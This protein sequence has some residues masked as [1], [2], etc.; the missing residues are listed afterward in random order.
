MLFAIT[1]TGLDVFDAARAWGLAALIGDLTQDEVRVRDIGWQFL[2]DSDSDVGT[3][4]QVSQFPIVPPDTD[5]VWRN[6]FVTSGES[7][8]Q[9]KIEK[10]RELIV[11]LASEPAVMQGIFGGD[12]SDHVFVSRGG[13]SLP[14]ALD[15]AAF[16]GVRQQTRA[17]YAEDQLKVEERHWALACLGMALCGSYRKVRTAGGQR[18]LV[19]LPIPHDVRVYQPSEFGELT[20]WTQE[21]GHAAAATMA[22]H[23]AVDLAARLRKRAAVY[24]Q[25]RDRFSEIVFF[26]LFR[27]GNQPKPAQ[28]NH[29]RLERLLTVVANDP[30]RAEG[31]LAWLDYCF[32]R[33]AVKGFQELAL[34]ATEFTFRWDLDSYERLVRVFVRMLAS[35][36]IKMVQRP[37]EEVMREV[38]GY[39]TI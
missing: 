1:K 14:G 30:H 6:V 32:R 5:S 29:V 39:V 31:I 36:G 3:V 10:V 21:V 27:T 16:K 2:V 28:G 11:R 8:R 7:E 33:G 9:K 4:G 23:A 34:A 13:E 35:G 15:P 20:R 37:S 18:Y 19:L 17:R 26:E 24:G 22:A 12:W 25:L 38:I